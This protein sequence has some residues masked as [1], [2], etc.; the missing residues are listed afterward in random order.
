MK[1]ML[2]TALLFLCG[3]KAVQKSTDTAVSVTANSSSVS[4]TGQ[5]EE[6]QASTKMKRFKVLGVISSDSGYEKVVEEEVFEYEPRQVDSLW[7]AAVARVIHTSRVIRERGS[8]QRQEI[9]QSSGEDSLQQNGHARASTTT[10]AETDSNSFSQ[11]TSRRVQRTGTPWYV[12]GGGV[13]I[14][15]AVVWWKKRQVGIG[16]SVSKD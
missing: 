3:C 4:S 14:M 10:H 8:T 15:A 7:N 13:T 6:S 5:L 11:Q 9:Q 12:W 16:I 2:I 1:A